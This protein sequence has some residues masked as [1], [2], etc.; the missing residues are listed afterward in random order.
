MRSLIYETLPKAQP[1]KGLGAF[2]TVTAFKSQ[3]KL[4]KFQ[5]KH[6]DQNF[7]SNS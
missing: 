5:L 7:A 4:I 2:T 6:L 1:T 3:C